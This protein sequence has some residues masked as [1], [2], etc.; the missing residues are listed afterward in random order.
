MYTQFTYE[1]YELKLYYVTGA[2][3]FLCEECTCST[4]WVS[5]QIF[6]LVNQNA[7]ISPNMLISADNR[8]VLQYIPFIKEKN[9]TGT[10]SCLIYFQKKINIVLPRYNLF[11]LKP[12]FYSD[13][14]SSPLFPRLLPIEVV[15]CLRSVLPR[16]PALEIWENLDWRTRGENFTAEDFPGDLG[17]SYC[18]KMFQGILV[19]HSEVCVFWSVNLSVF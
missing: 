8:Y 17:R 5:A 6:T 1:T 4:C 2:F 11:A 18:Q 19:A 3:I 13:F 7:T 15:E 14:A 9:I 12:R 16:P 10:N